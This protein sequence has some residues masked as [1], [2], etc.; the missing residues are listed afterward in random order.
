MMFGRRAGVCAPEGVAAA[1]TASAAPPPAAV[2]NTLR[3]VSN[4]YKATRE[5]PVSRKVSA[6]IAIHTPIDLYIEAKQLH[7]KDGHKFVSN[8]VRDLD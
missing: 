4:G 5:F 2:F 3:R 7:L 8:L 1:A 6:D